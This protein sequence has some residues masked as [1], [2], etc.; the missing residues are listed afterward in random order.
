MIDVKELRVGNLVDNLGDI[1]I[2]DR[3]GNSFVGTNKCTD[4]TDDIT[5]IPITEDWLLRFGFEYSGI[6]KNKL[7]MVGSESGDFDSYSVFDTGPCTVFVGDD[8]F[9]FETCHYSDN[10]GS[11]HES[12]EIK[13]VH[14][15]QN[16]YY[17]FHDSELELKE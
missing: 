12:K 13:H 14:K 6:Y 1:E 5:A 16:L 3:I 15:L 17:E 10:Y 8:R 7:M 4:A 9:H 11:H 2:V